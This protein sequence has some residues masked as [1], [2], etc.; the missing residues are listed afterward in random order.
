MVRM[1]TKENKKKK[2][3]LLFDP[4]RDII[5]YAGCLILIVFTFVLA[6]IS[7]STDN[8]NTYVEIKYQ[9]TLLYVKDDKEKNTKISFPEEGEKKITF[10]KE[11]ASIYI[12]GLEN[13]DF[14]GENVTITLY[15]DKSIQIIK[16]EITCNDHVCS[17]MGRIYEVDIPI[18]CLVNHI[19]VM[20]KSN[21]GLPESVN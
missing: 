10:Q 5:L 18:V 4:V 1:K 20:I 15:S 12:Q 3:Y 6:L 2:N 9:D 14:M 16:E 11:D 8:K 7:K 17:K 19:Q 21:T 13:F